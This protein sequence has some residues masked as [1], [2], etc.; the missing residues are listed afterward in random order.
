MSPIESVPTIWDDTR[1]GAFFRIVSHALDARLL[2]AASSLLAAN[3]PEL[4]PYP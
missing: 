3:D 2:E 4:A 1:D